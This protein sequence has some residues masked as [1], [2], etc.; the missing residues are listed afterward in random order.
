MRRVITSRQAIEEGVRWSLSAPQ[1]TRCVNCSPCR[2][3]RRTWMGLG[4]RALII[5]TLVSLVRPTKFLPTC[6]RTTRHSVRATM[7][8]T[9]S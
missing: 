7:L 6:G 2:A 1:S 5:G 4:S 3:S 8:S 9:A